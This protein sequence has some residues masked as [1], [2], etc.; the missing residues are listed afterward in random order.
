[1]DAIKMVFYPLVLYYVLMV[2]LAEDL[3]SQTRILGVS[4]AVIYTCMIY[5]A[6]KK[7]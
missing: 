4:L 1:M 2:T 3:D 7:N 6:W 5:E